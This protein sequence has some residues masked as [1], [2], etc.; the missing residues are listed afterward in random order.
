M[1][2]NH[3]QS[4]TVFLPSM[5]VPGTPLVPYEP[6][7]F[8]LPQ[9]GSLTVGVTGGIDEALGY[10]AWIKSTELERT[11]YATRFLLDAG[12]PIPADIAEPEDLVAL[13]QSVVKWWASVLERWHGTCWE[14]TDFGFPWFPGIW[15]EGDPCAEMFRVERSV[16][17]DL[18]L[19]L[20]AAARRVRDD[21]VWHLA[22][23]PV[24]VGSGRSRQKFFL[25]TVDDEHM[26]LFQATSGILHAGYSQVER[27]SQTPDSREE[28]I[29]QVYRWLITPSQ[30]IASADSVE[31]TDAV[32]PRVHRLWQRSEWPLVRPTPNAPAPPIE[33]I[34]AV[35]A[36]RNAGWYSPL[37]R[38][39]DERLA[40]TLQAT[41]RAADGDELPLT[42]PSLDQ[43]LIVMDESRT[44]S[45]DVEADVGEGQNVYIDLLR[46][47]AK[48]SGGSFEVKAAKEDWDHDADKV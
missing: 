16:A 38:Y 7:Q 24:I 37:K 4:S 6:I 39:G 8:P 15:D 1:S 18:G 44:W 48:R 2:S 17:F 28:F 41:F 13:G 33:L 11:P 42:P 34:E 43:W 26:S 46:V 47:L 30:S 27:L 12:A 23:E 31:V 14:L 45:E 22:R 10:L 19:V 32:A 40:A 29:V 35:R 21:L 25:P 20:L 36:Y 5:G 3:S 9:N